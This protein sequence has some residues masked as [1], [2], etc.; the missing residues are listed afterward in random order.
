MCDSLIITDYNNIPETVCYKLSVWDL[1]RTYS[2]LVD[3]Y[4]SNMQF[5][6]FCNNEHEDL[7]MFRRLLLLLN[8]YDT[9]DITSDTTD[10]NVITYSEIKNILNILKNK[11]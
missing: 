4:L 6:I 1:Q 2:I 9:R 8:R 10:F 3:K 11:Y 7:K 5:G